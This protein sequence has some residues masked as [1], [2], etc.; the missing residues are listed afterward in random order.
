MTNLEWVLKNQKEYIENLLKARPNGT[1]AVATGKTTLVE[2]LSNMCDVDLPRQQLVDCKV[3]HMYGD[4]KEY[5]YAETSSIT[6]WLNEERLMPL[7]PACPIGT[8]LV[9]DD[10]NWYWYVGIDN[11]GKNHVVVSRVTDINKS[12]APSSLYYNDDGFKKHFRT[13]NPRD[14]LD[15]EIN[16]VIAK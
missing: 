15:F 12:F 7:E 1:I 4:L 9:G 13:L 11:S 16:L 3:E 5:Y 8:I 10:D 2:V 6:L 14:D